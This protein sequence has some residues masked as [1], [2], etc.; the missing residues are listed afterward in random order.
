MAKK[1]LLVNGRLAIGWEVF[2]AS[3]RFLHAQG[4]LEDIRS[5]LPGVMQGM[6]NMIR[7][8]EI[9]DIANSSRLAAQALFDILKSTR[10]FKVSDRRDKII[11]ILGMVGDL[12]PQ[13]KALSD[14]KLSVSQIY[15]RATLYLI[16]NGL[17]V[18]MLEHAGLQRQTEVS[19]IPSWVPDWHVDNKGLNERPLSLFRPTPFKAGGPW[20]RCVIVDSGDSTYPGEICVFGYCHHTIIKQSDPFDP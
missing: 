9:K 19:G 18:P 20:G 1:T 12:P 6:L 15:H 4:F 3:F 5:T 17:A 13:L 2:E 14:Y 7:M 16:E 8:R 11:G 10:H